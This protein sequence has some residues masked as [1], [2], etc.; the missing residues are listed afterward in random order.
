MGARLAARRAEVR[1]E[2]SL[3][4]GPMKSG[5]SLDLIAQMAPLA[6]SRLSCAVVQSARHVRDARIVSR[7][8]ASVPTVKLDSLR[9]LLDTDEDVVAIDEVHMF[10]PAD[11][12][13][14]EEL[15]LRGTRVLACGIDLDHRGE[16]FATV[17]ALLELGPTEVRYRRAVCDRCQ[18][19]HAAFTQVLSGGL[20]FLDRLGASE[21]LPDDGT[22]T[23]EALCRRCFVLPETAIVTGTAGV[24]RASADAAE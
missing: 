2:L 17:R 10:A 7:T 4:L 1:V 8:G 21:P 22:F 20:P 24:V 11:V 18:D 19:L 15:V 5:K 23:Y 12:R 9:P 16:L 3:V 13:V 6:Y 14:V